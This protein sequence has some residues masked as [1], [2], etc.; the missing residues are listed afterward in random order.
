M[1]HPDFDP[2]RDLE[3]RRTIRAPRAAVWSAW[4]DPRKF[5]RWWVPAPAV[6]RV[7]AM[8]LRPGG[9]FR[10]EISE[11][12][13]SFGPHIDGCFLAIEPGERLVFTTSLT[14]GW[15]PASQPFITAVISLADHPDGT[16]YVAHVMHKDTA[17]KTMHL[18][19]GFHDGWGTVADQL[20]RFVETT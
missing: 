17:D 14:E 11:D 19:L 13:G 12:G 20:A 1:T 6:C 4:T 9:A 16:D 2:E 8:D 15:R 7:A 18:D 3:L 10:T 5:E